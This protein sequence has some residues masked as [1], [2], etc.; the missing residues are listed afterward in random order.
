MEWH[1]KGQYESY[2]LVHLFSDES[3]T[4]HADRNIRK[5]GKALCR[6]PSQQNRMIPPLLNIGQRRGSSY[7]KILLERKTILKAMDRIYIGFLLYLITVSL[8]S[9]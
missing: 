8:V 4:W 7:T 1:A 2:S 3:L 5:D 6:G 9:I